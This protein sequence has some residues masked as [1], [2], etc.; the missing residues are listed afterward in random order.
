M[1]IRGT[2]AGARAFTLI[3]LLVVI[4]IIALL[5]GILLPA[6]GK[7]RE[8]GKTLLCQNNIRSIAQAAMVYATDYRGQFPPALGG[9]YVIDPQNDRQNMVWYDVNRIGQYL[10]QE[11]YRNL[12]AN[13]IMNETVGGGVMECPNHP[14]AGRSYTMNYWAASAAEVT[15]L[16]QVTGLPRFLKPGTYQANQRTFNKGQAFTDSSARASKTLLFGEAWGLF[17]SELP[18][19]ADLTWFS[20]ATIG[21]YELPGERFGGGNGLDPITFN[22]F[23]S[24][25]NWRANPTSPE[26]GA[27]PSIMPTSYLPYYRH[28]P[29]SG[30]L[31]AID[32][33]ANIAFV[34][35]HVSRLGPE[36]LFEE[37]DEETA[38][39]TY[40]VL[41]SEKDYALERDL[42]GKP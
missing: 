25:S 36:Q 11:D 29:R 14:D 21:A 20:G 12:S 38:K 9:Q 16:D 32:G 13:N 15:A 23:Q 30:D 42:D 31:K 26:L 18:D 5:I 34:D 1:K 17:R 22:G 27:D 3:E 2:P 40:E 19:G 6:I 28:P 24:N 4:A 41:W 33:T 7:A 39:S 37:I 35:G 10:P 8:S